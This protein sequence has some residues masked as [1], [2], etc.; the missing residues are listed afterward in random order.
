M[1]GVGLDRVEA[2]GGGDPG[3]A[4]AAGLGGDGD[5]RCTASAYIVSPDGGVD[6]YSFN[7]FRRYHAE[8]HMC[9]GPNGEGSTIAPPL[10]EPLRGM[11][12]ATFQDVVARGVRNVGTGRQRVM[13]AMGDDRNVMCYLQDIYVY[14]KARADGALGRGRPDKHEPKPDIATQH[15]A[16]CLDRT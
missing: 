15:E 1:L 8:C 16:A 14:L 5:S 12:Y 9:H 11:D 3:G 10:L 6:W 2:A 13:R 4:D 7:G